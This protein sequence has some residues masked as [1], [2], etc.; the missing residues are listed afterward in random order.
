MAT[1]IVDGE[2]GLKNVIDGEIS[3]GLK[4]DGQ[5]GVIYRAGGGTADYNLLKN[6]P[7]IEG[8]TLQGNKSFKELGLGMLSVQEIEKI[9]YL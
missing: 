9:L 7:E 1:I 5:A 6:K 8:V 3:G 4:I 2:Q